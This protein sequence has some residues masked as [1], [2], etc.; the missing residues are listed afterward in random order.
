M[1]AGPDMPQLEDVDS[2][3]HASGWLMYVGPTG[4]RDS[5]RGD[6]RVI[7]IFWEL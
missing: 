2:S 1:S 4:M 6:C 7:Y 5:V 3:G